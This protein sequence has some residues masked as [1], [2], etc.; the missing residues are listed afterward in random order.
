MRC[1]RSSLFASLLLVLLL[2]EIVSG[3]VLPRDKV[4]NG[5]YILFRNGRVLEQLHADRLFIPASTIKLLTAYTALN[6]LGEDFRFTT[7][8]FLDANRVLYIQG[9]GDPVL[10]TESLTAVAR[11]LKNRG[12]TRISAYVIDNSA[13]QLEQPFPDGSE[14]SANPYDVSN[15][16]MAVNFNSI[17]ISKKKDGTVASAEE[18]TPLTPLG[19][20]IARKLPPGTHRVNI[21]AFQLQGATPLSLR[22][23]AELLHALLA[24]EG[25]VSQPTI[26]R[27]GIPNQAR[28]IYQH[29]SLSTVREI[30]AACLQVSNNFM[31]NQLALTAGAVHYGYPATWEKARR[32][33]NLYARERLGISRDELQVMEGSGLSRQTRATPA[34][35]LKIL[36]GFEPYREL[37]PEKEGALLKSG[38]MENVYC[39][40]GYMDSSAGALLFVVLLNQ[41]ENTRKELITRLRQNFLPQVSQQIRPKSL[42]KK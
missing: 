6:T 9:G 14:R 32:I 36:K 41:Q 8:F 35:M 18:Q 20:E 7:S 40:A 27:G 22:Y 5:G 30:V 39:Y 11:A 25:V 10:T 12:V 19:R 2:P 13:F 38:T 26:R 3:A 34:A 33:L 17:A 15:S 16:G 4:K 37:L 29:S 31:A 23:S 1:R 28:L 21:D 24:G 42:L